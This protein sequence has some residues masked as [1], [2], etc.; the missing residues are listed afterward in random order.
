MKLMAA[1]FI[2]LLTSSP[3]L[4]VTAHYFGFPQEASTIT[5]EN[6]VAPAKILRENYDTPFI[7]THPEDGSLQL[8]LLYN[9]GRRQLTVMMIGK[10]GS[11]KYMVHDDETKHWTGEIS[12]KWAEV[13]AFATN[14]PTL[15][16]SRL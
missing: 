2:A 9:A 12:I 4:Q 5:K 1:A 8:E 14:K 6:W 7:V 11:V 3:F 13:H 10:E 15:Y 16:F